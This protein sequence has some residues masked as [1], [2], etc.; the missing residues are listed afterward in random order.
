MY[1]TI[2]K[3]D[4]EAEGGVILKFNK[5]IYETQMFFDDEAQFQA[6]CLALKMMLEMKADSLGC[7]VP[8][9]VITEKQDENNKGNH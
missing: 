9:P 6:F 5:G 1:K 8:D 4:R 2:I 3:I 7:M